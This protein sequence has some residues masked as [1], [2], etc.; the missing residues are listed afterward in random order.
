VGPC[1]S[2]IVGSLEAWKGLNGILME[3]ALKVGIHNTLLISIIRVAGLVQGMSIRR[4]GGIVE[5]K[6]TNESPNLFLYTTV[7]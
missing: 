7:I 1:S 6:N 3:I 2:S 5:H 4:Y